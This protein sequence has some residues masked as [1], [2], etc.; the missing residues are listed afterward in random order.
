VP[1]PAAGA[2]PGGT[3]LGRRSTTS[4][5]TGIGSASDRGATFKKDSGRFV[6]NVCLEY[7]EDWPFEDKVEIGYVLGSEFWG[8]GYDA[9]A[10]RASMRQGFDVVGLERIIS[11]TYADHWASR[12][13]MQKCGMT[14]QGNIRWRDADIA[15]HAADR[16]SDAR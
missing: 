2:A 7:M 15:W 6:G 11:T 4:W 14:F 9:E 5:A 3:G 16:P 1:P 13:V 12:K 10:A 8:L